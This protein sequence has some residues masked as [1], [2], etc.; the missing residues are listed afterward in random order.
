MSPDC[1]TG[2]LKIENLKR[3]FFLW[4]DP[5][6]WYNHQQSELISSLHLHCGRDNELSLRH[7]LGRGEV[8]SSFMTHGILIGFLFSKDLH[9]EK[10]LL[11]SNGTL[12]VE[13]PD[14]L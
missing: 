5:K 6:F 4:N 12:T 2:A 7:T 13:I 8:T 14:Q 10:I 9:I 1:S 11:P 3:P